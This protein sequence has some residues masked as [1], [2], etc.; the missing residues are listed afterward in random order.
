VVFE[1]QQ[2]TY[3]ELNERANQLAHHLGKHGVGPEVL[4][5]ICVE[6]SLEMVVGLLG[7]LKA[8]GAYVPLDP[9]YPK[10]RLSFMIDDAAAP[11]LLTQERLVEGLPESEAEVVRL[12][13]DWPLIA[14]EAKDDFDG[15]VTADNLAYVIYTS[16][17]TGQPKGVMI[18]HRTFYGFVVAAAE[19]RGITESDRV[20]QFSSLS[21]DNSIGQIFPPLVRGGTLVLRTER[22]VDSIQRFVRECRDQ[23]I[24]VLSLP[25]A[26]WHELVAAFDGEGL[27]LPPAVR[28]TIIAGE[29][30]LAR[31]VTQW[32]EHVARTGHR[33]RLINV[34][35]PTEATAATTQGELHP[36]AGRGDATQGGASIGRP[37]GRARIYIL[38]GSMNL[39]PIGVAGELHVG[40]PVLARGY[41]NR[42]ELT[43]EQFIAD[44]FSDTPEARLYKTGDVARWRT[45]GNIEFLGRV[46]EQV[47]I[48][49]FRVE[50]GE[51]ESIL[52]SHPAVRGSVV[53]LREDGPDQKHLVAY[54]VPRD[55]DP[56]IDELRGYLK[57]RLPEYMVPSA[58]VTLEALPLTPNGKVNR[59]ALPAPD[60]SGFRAENAYAEPRTP[61][62]GQLVEIWEEVLG[63]E[64]VGVHDD[65]FELGGHSLLAARVVTRLNRHF[66]VE[67]P[68]RTLFEEPTIEGLALAV[69]QMQAEA[70]I[71]IEQMLAQVEQMQGHSVPQGS[72]EG[73]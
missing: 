36:G 3:R 15:G 71:D 60:P 4:V 25:T 17:S 68:L 72:S 58:F 11:V 14:Q 21:F 23:Q 54:I 61:V 35:G 64:R 2:L 18:E 43:S 1:E 56:A 62:E 24:S 55:T 63:L 50:P 9:S 66:R 59:K 33:V 44:P 29:K 67:L 48:R 30:A 40:G 70:E 10:E 22:M 53:V 47:K 27:A 32:H 45:D 69:T 31:R 42:P 34:Y 13:A 5:G 46:D 8:G 39:V 49:S 28:L 12:D 19:S 65:F 52:S 51:I 6:R 37:L 57:G 16:G 41:L 7:I 38:D 26:F 73:Q 20:L